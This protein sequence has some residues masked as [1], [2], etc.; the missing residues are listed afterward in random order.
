MPMQSTAAGNLATVRRF[1]SAIR[2]GDLGGAS[3]LL[4]ENFVLSA[5]GGLP[6]S[7]NYHGRSDFIDL[8]TR[9]TDILQLTAAQ[10]A[11]DS[12]PD[13]TVISRLR[14]TFTE[15]ATGRSV[16]MGVIELYN[17]DNGLIASLDVYYKDP[18]AVAAL[19]TPSP[20]VISTRD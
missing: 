7:G 20:S 8:L 15:R 10:S 12:V 9:M 3:S 16:E 11:Q 1:M 2:H 13:N 4:H 14:L 18:T 19:W 6:Y 17:L 5:A